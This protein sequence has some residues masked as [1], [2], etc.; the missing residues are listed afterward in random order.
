MSCAASTKSVRACWL[1]T[2]SFSVSTLSSDRGSDGVTSSTGLFDSI[3][4][5]IVS[6]VEKM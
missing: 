6:I 3:R 1:S 4:G 5:T 2:I